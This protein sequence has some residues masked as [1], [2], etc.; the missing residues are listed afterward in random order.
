MSIGIVHSQEGCTVSTDCGYTF[1]RDT[2]TIL[3]VGSGSEDSQGP[4]SLLGY[5]LVES[6]KRG[7]WFP[8]G[9]VWVFLYFDC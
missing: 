2:L 3:S 7:L 1:K 9:I 8:R 6:E 4:W 5:L